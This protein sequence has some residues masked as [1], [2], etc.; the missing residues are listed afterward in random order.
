MKCIICKNEIG[1]WDK[2][3]NAESG[4]C[5]ATCNWTVVIP[6]RLMKRESNGK[7]N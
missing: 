5:C 3:H 6:A 1:G 2:G 7:D 4:R